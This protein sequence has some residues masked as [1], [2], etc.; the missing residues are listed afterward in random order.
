MR[1]PADA[2]VFEVTYTGA[3][4]IRNGAIVEGFLE[5][6]GIKDDSPDIPGLL[7]IRAIDDADYIGPRSIYYDACVK[8][9]GYIGVSTPPECVRP[10]TRAAR[11]MIAIVKK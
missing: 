10:L 6:T 3:N 2:V 5:T 7:G 8:Q 11:Q 1:Y 4:K 9:L